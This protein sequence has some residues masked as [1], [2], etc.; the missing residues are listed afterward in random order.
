MTAAV[1]DAAC[2]GSSL[3]GWGVQPVQPPEAD[4]VRECGRTSA[5]TIL[6][7]VLVLMVGGEARKLASHAVYKACMVPL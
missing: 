3:H 6:Q 7:L 5:T 4:G 1:N 2:G